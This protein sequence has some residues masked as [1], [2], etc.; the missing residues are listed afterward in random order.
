MD[1]DDYFLPGKIAKFLPE[2]KDE[3]IGI[4][5][6]DYYMFSD[7]GPTTRTYKEPYDRLRLFQECLIHS[8]AAF[9]KKALERIGIKKGDSVYDEVNFPFRAEDWDLWLRLTKSCIATHVPEALTMVRGHLNNLS[10]LTQESQ[11]AWN[12]TWKKIQ[13]NMQNNVY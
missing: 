6:G 3:N 9:S 7:D 4:V 2:F 12:D 11:Q 5:Y 13:Q 8:G 1:A 10:R